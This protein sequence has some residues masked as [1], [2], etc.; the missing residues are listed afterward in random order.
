MIKLSLEPQPT[1]DIE[2]CV[3]NLNRRLSAKMK[4]FLTVSEHNSQNA[5]N[6]TEHHPPYKEPENSQE[7]TNVNI[8]INLMLE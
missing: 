3:L 8:E 5:H 6:T 7:S 4:G 2:T 1:K